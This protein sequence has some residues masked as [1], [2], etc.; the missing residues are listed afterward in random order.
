[1]D[2]GL[3]GKRALVTGSTAGIGLAIAK[4]L[5]AEGATVWVNGRTQE[6]VDA[7]VLEVGNGSKGVVADLGTAAGCDTL[8][9]SLPEIDI[10][11]NNLG[12]FETKPFLEIGDEEWSRFFE[13]NVLSG[14]RVTRQ[15]LKGMLDGKWGRVLFISSESGVQIPEEM[16][17]YGVT[18]A[19]QIALARGIAESVPASG[20]TV[21]SLLPGPTESEGVSTLI[22]KIAKEK[23][24]SVEQV[25]SDFIRDARPSSLIKR[26]AKVEEVAA[27]A[28]YLCSEQ[29]SA[30]NGSPIRV[31]GGVVKSA[32]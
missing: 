29:A 26:L 23:G 30:T 17:H 3:R 9:A 27:M 14:V 28:T 22:G 18:K 32:Y 10:L 1:M 5:A 4:A 12:I 19:A 21:N 15:Y 16:V 2:L 8:F 7:A 6:R 31:D 24:V 20:V 25:E 11:V 13:T